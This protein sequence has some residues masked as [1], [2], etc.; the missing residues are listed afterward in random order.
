MIK[1]PL[2][3]IK[4]LHLLL[5]RL[6]M[7]T[8]DDKEQFAWQY[9]DGRTTKTSELTIKEYSLLLLDLQKLTNK[10][11]AANAMRRKIISKAHEMSWTTLK[12]DIV[13]ADIKRIDD[14]CKRYGYL[15]KGFNEYTAQELPRLVSQFD[16]VYRDFLKRI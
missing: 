12:N 6:N 8:A 13:K 5:N 9:S 1:I 10:Q 15:H 14:W 11:D 16:N 3:K 7:N 2:N 4:T